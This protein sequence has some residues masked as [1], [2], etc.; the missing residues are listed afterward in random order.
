MAILTAFPG[1][2]GLGPQSLPNLNIDWGGT[3]ATAL[4]SCVVWSE[5]QYPH[6]LVTGRLCLQ[7]NPGFQNSRMNVGGI[8]QGYQGI[9][10]LGPAN[11]IYAAS[12]T[13]LILRRLVVTGENA[14]HLGD[15]G[16]LNC[17]MPWSDST[18]YW[19]Y[20][21]GSDRVAAAVTPTTGMELWVLHGGARGR[22]IWCNNRNLSTVSTPTTTASPGSGNFYI[23][24]GTVVGAQMEMYL[25]ASW[26]RQLENAEII[27]I[28]R[29]PYGCLFGTPRLR[30]AYA[31]PTS[32]PPPPPP[33]STKLFR[34]A[35]YN[36]LGGGGPFFADP[37]AAFPE[38]R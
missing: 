24:N 37:L 9:W 15:A 13:F 27:E 10:T 11:L 12:S 18:V 35:N 32:P 2:D 14:S 17:H 21:G 6:D 7:S 5:G 26:G 8:G 36:G 33:P 29:D 19:D 25:F 38:V 1:I 30:I 28:S 31:S 23:N 4:K 34:P 16:G 22:G 20:P 3:F